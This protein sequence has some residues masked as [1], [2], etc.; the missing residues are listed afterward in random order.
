MAESWT[1]VKPDTLKHSWRK[2]W[3]EVITEID[4]IEDE[5]NDMQEIINSLQTIDENI[6]VGEIEEWIEC[7]KNCE[8]SEVFNDDQIVAAVLEH[9]CEEYVN[10]DSDGDHDE[11]T[12]R[13]SHTDAKNTFE[14]GF[15]YIEQNAASTPI[16]ILWIKK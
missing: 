14:I 16:D 9:D 15:Q 3:P 11:P 2:L 4:Q 10:E 12:S 1:E 7:D 5:Q 6:P 8:T 13:I